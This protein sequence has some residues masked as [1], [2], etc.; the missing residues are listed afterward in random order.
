MMGFMNYEIQFEAATALF[1]NGKFEES[2]RKFQDLLI[3][4]SQLTTQQHF[5]LLNYIT[6]CQI[7]LDE[8]EQA[9]EHLA[10]FQTL[11]ETINSPEALYY[12]EMK[13]GSP[14]GSSP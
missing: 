13:K 8:M 1:K 5:D 14:R 3:Y 9:F 12:A 10:V 11:A 2:L 4:E 6:N 7:N